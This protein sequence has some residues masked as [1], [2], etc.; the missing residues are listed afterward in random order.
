[1][2]EDICEELSIDKLRADLR[3]SLAGYKMPTLLRIVKD[4]RKNATGKVS[5]KVL[6]QE[7]F[8]TSGH[9]DVQAWKSPNGN[10]VT[11]ARL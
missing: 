4:L 3:G 1:L 2:R 5:K 8:P 9:P 7:L 11:E 6:V 10:S